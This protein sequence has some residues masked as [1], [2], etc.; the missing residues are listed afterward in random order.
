MSEKSEQSGPVTQTTTTTTSTNRTVLIA[1]LALFVGSFA[2]LW[3]TGNTAVESSADEYGA[4]PLWALTVPVLVGLVLVRLV[5]PRAPGELAGQVRTALAG[6]RAGAE[7]VLL[8]ACLVVFIV[9]NLALGRD[10]DP[11]SPAALLY[12]ASKLLLF[13]AVPWIA[14]RLLR[15]TPPAS[16]SLRRIATL[17]GAWWRWGGVVAVAVTL[18]LANFTPL[19]PPSP[20]AESLPP[21][22][23]LVVSMLITFLTASVLEEV[24][25]RVWLQTRLEHVV[26]PWAGIVV[27]SLLFGVMHVASHHALGSPPLILAQV[28][29]VQGVSGLLYGYLWSRYRNVWLII[30]L[31]T[32]VNSIALL[33]VLFA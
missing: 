31:H 22:E 20:T 14:L 1:G 25:F 11:D 7:S 19:A 3:A 5:P 16:P 30:A 8:V 13:L 21:I 26:G 4:T 2:L 27:S 28:I 12:P 17:P 23:V 18:Y 24:F 33:P 32:G 29:A 10:A 9:A 15:P 6:R